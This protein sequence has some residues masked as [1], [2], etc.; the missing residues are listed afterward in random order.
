MCQVNRL[1]YRRMMY[2]RR[3]FALI[4]TLLIVVLVAIIAVSFLSSIASER[5]TAHAYGNVARS[6]FA[7]D[8]AVQSGMARLRH[9]FERYPMSA[10]AW[11][12][13][14]DFVGTTFHF[15]VIDES[16]K[17]AQGV[18][19]LISGAKE[20]SASGWQSGDASVT[21]ARVSKAFSDESNS[22]DIN[23]ARHTVEPGGWI[24]SPAGQPRKVVRVPW[25][26]LRDSQAK[27]IARYA[28]WI[29]DESFKI[30][31]ND[32]GIVARD[33]GSP[34]VEPSEVPLQGLLNAV[35]SRQ[36][37]GNASVELAEAIARSVVALRKSLPGERMVDW[38]ALN[39]LEALSSSS[40]S[41]GPVSLLGAQ[42]RYYGTLGSESLNVTLQGGKR[43]NINSAFANTMDGE[44]VRLQID[45]VTT[46][47]RHHL[48]H[49]GE[50]FYRLS[51][52]LN[53]DDVSDEHQSLYIEKIAVNMRDAIMPQ[54]AVP[55]LVVADGSVQMGTRPKRGI[56]PLPGAFWPGSAFAVFKG[57]DNSARALGKKNI[58]YLQEWACHVK[59][60]K[61]DTTSSKA[62]AGFAFS[63]NYYFE[64]WNMSP[65]DIDARKGDLGSNPFLR[66]YDQPGFDTADGTVIPEGRAFD[67]P[68]DGVVFPA[69][70]TT[71]VTTAPSSEMNK[72]LLTGSSSGTPGTN[73]VWV[74]VPDA[75]RQF[76]GITKKATTDKKF[77]VNLQSRSTSDA[78]D[79]ETK[80]VLGNDAGMIDGFC[81]LP[82]ARGKSSNNNALSLHNDNASDPELNVITGEKNHEQ[83]FVRGGSLRGNIRMIGR[84]KL[85]QTG[86]P[87]S[88]NEQLFLRVYDKAG[89]DEQTRYYNSELDNYNGS[90]IQVPAAST[91]GQ[92]NANYVE[93]RDWPDPFTW[94]GDGVNAPAYFP[95]GPMRSIGELGHIYDPAR[96]LG[97]SGNILY[98]RGGGRTLAI[99]QPDPLWDGDEQ[100]ASAGW[101]A[102]KLVDL[103]STTSDLT[104]QGRV[105]LNGVMRDDG[106]ALRTL[107]HGFQY[108]TDAQGDPGLAAT[109]LPEARLAGI[110]DALQKR[111]GKEG[112]LFERGELSEFLGGESG[113]AYDRGR[114]ELFRRMVELTT[115]RGSL[116]T[117]YAIGQAAKETQS[118]EI[119]AGAV[120][121]LKVTFRLVPVWR[122]EVDEAFDPARPEA[123]AARFRRPDRFAV[124]IVQ[125]EQ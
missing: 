39:S 117:L 6:G 32:T 49:F 9:L 57:G 52:N 31:L 102:W 98:S 10:T 120:A 73:I 16:G 84:G 94:R 74:A 41:A 29:E 23:A 47:I 37:G 101:R 12:E 25:V 118:G 53:A 51:E 111:L 125:V 22:I 109:A 28:Y 108:S 95:A 21:L 42:L 113:A 60:H 97:P 58:P 89:D 34:G 48:P 5:V 38:N 80:V 19:P 15:R 103:F 123:V 76:A 44:A 13:R 106:V 1:S 92:P 66:V 81:A 36:G 69:G 87:R 54:G 46:A 7:A 122:E 11:E 71:V 100:S 40:G 83:Y 70:R 24:G 124:E 78:T 99:G 107:L 90:D 2:S 59:L 68:L 61:F 14:G 115:T 119:I 112:P 45:R 96:V 62:Q 75:D 77:R 3:A 17:A 65:V 86:D 105:N 55:T 43:M 110:I 56:E 121:R 64:F 50:R 67:V 20:L 91:L 114:E 35:A 88:A 8:A 85:A 72:T 30:S 33:V 18:I 93:P 63:L 26:E 82:L 27:L 104:L 4:S 116:F 79:Y